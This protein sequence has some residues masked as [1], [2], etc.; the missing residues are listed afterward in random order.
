ML[1][2]FEIWIGLLTSACTTHAIPMRRQTSGG[3]C[4]VAKGVFNFCIVIDRNFIALWL[5]NIIPSLVFHVGPGLV[6]VG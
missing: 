3:R 6:K 1:G 2:A 4:L 5:P